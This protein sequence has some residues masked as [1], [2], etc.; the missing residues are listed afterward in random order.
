MSA[1][2]S[3]IDVPDGYSF[4]NTSIDP[5]GPGKVGLLDK[6]WFEMMTVQVPARI[7]TVLKRCTMEIP[8]D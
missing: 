6:S 5:N 8:A 7:D 2:G 3:E 1:T 4:R